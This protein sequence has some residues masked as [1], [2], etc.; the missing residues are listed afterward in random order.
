MSQ[1]NAIVLSGG[2]LLFSDDLGRLPPERHEK[3]ARVAELSARCFE[4]WPLAIDVM[5]GEL[6]TLFYNSAGYLGVFNSGDRSAPRRVDLAR[7]PI[8]GARP[9]GLQDV[10]S[11]ETIDAADGQPVVLKKMPAHSSRLFRVIVE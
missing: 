2:P 1:I 10:W 3:M 8:S 11:G 4:G 5:E 9:R 6:P 7:L